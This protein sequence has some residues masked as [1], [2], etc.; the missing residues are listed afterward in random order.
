MKDYILND[1]DLEAA[2]QLDDFLPSQ[3]FDAHMHITHEKDFPGGEDSFDTYLRDLSPFSGDRKLFCNGIVYPTK[4]L[5]DP[6]Q[7]RLSDSFLASQ[8]QR[9]PHNVGE[10]QILP[11]ESVEDIEKRLIHPRI[12]G[13]KCYHIFS[14]RSDTFSSSI[15][16]YLPE[17]AWQVANEKGLVITLHMVKDRAL[18]DPDNLSYIKKMAKAYPNATLILAHAA[19]SFAAWTVFGTVDELVGLENVWYDF[20]GICESPSLQYIMK[21][22]GTDRC[23][24]GTDYP[25]SRLAGKAISIADQFYWIGERDLT[26]FQSKTAFRCWH[27]ITEELYAFRQAC[28]LAELDRKKIEDVFY[29]NAARL[30]YQ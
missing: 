17:S 26:N 21:K 29:N 7:L 24:W 9:Y 13:L 8:L 30:F 27:V 16:E 20:S 5:S 18:A 10:I 3:M 14:H 23:M 11:C 22:V 19:R 15:G 12:R 4:N 2:K 6:D 25:V 28:I 1:Y